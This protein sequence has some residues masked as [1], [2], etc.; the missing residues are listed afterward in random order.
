MTLGV[1]VNSFAEV[2]RRGFGCTRPIALGCTG[3]V[4]GEGSG[5]KGAAPPPTVLG[6]GAECTDDGVGDI[7]SR[8]WS[9]LSN[10]GTG[11]SG[12]RPK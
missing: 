9:D 4:R 11:G 3:V 5:L 1:S 2:T 7:D 6:D 12:T 10:S 8:S